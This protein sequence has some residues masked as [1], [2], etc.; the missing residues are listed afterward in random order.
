MVGALHG[1]TD[2]PERRFEMGFTSNNVENPNSTKHKSDTHGRPFDETNQ[3]YND[4][5]CC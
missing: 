1:D 2:L 3:R 5:G 4:R